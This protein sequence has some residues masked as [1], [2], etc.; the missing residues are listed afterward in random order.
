MAVI[1]SFTV[2]D[3]GKH[4]VLKALM[5]CVTEVAEESSDSMVY[6][7]TCAILWW[8]M[9]IFVLVSFFSFNLIPG[10]LPPTL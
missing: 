4:V 9:H 3:A 1:A 2:T 6:V 7:S 5:K 8:L 10:A